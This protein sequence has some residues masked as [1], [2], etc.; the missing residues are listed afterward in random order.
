MIV[1]MLAAF[2]ILINLLMLGSSRLGVLIRTVAGQALFLCLLVIFAQTER[3]TWHEWLFLAAT[4]VVKS[5]ALPKLLWRT[6]REA[7]IR[8]DI[9][10]LV[11][12]SG[13]LFLGLVLLG[14]CLLGASRLPLPEG[15]VNPLILT[16]MFFTICSGLQLVVSRSKA[17]T[18]VIG[19]L[20]MENGIY[21]LGLVV[22]ANSPLIVEM[23]I[24]L[25]VLVGIF[26]MGI[27]INHIN[28]DF[29]HIDT[30][31]LNTL[32]D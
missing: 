13:S 14:A 29:D 24:L 15:R 23:G 6:L 12:Y 11:G 22:A 7:A 19:Y 3:L 1:Q 17:I 16:A 5:Y 25:D 2:L 9:E 20:C 4:I 18:Q 30:S 28:R 32:K 26:I 31:Q 21:G 27:M 8:R 10:P